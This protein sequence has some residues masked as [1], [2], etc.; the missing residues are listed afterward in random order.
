MRDMKIGLLIDGNIDFPGGVQTYVKGLYRFLLQ[1]GHQAVII[2]G[3]EKGKS[4][5]KSFNV[6]RMGRAFSLPGVGTQISAYTDWVGKEKIE[7]VLEREEFDILHLQGIF[8][9][10]GMRFLDHTDTP[11]IAT[12]HNYWE[13]ERLPTSAKLLFPLFDHYIK[14]LDARIADSQPALEFASQ[15]SPGSYTII[16][17]GV[18][19]G[20]F[21][22]VSKRRS[23][24]GKPITLLF[25]GRLD[26]RKGILFLLEAFRRVREEVD[27]VRLVIVGDGPLK[28]GAQRFVTRYKLKE[29]EFAGF[30]E[31]EELPH[32]YAEAD[33]YCSPAI[34][35][36]SFGIVLLE[37]MASGLPV[38]AFANAG[39]REVIKGAGAKFL[40]PP[41]D[42]GKLTEALLALVEDAELRKGMSRWSSDEVEQYSWEN[43]GPRILQMYDKIRSA[44]SS[45]I[46]TLNLTA[47][48]KGQ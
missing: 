27:N 30:V 14:K 38:V 23:P 43:V 45:P 26:K 42:V 16:P 4:E 15:V 17:P 8:G 37:A 10:L 21:K 34:Y 46:G 2:A 39:Y 5:Q 35:G 20:R 11:S 22:K 1:A 3:G 29:V 32:F 9:V 33:I 31:E 24:P 40:A 36:E 19:L 48:S 25:V 18:D 44:R 41:K 47:T 7:E 28:N 13:P 12:F 6:I